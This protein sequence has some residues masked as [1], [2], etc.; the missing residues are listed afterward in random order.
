MTDSIEL[1][2][3]AIRTSTSYRVAA[4]LPVAK[5]G[6]QVSIAGLDWEISDSTSQND[7]ADARNFVS[8]QGSLP[9]N[10]GL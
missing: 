9:L 1:K 4:R 2:R 8:T 6:S 5:G 10:F 7:V 3:C